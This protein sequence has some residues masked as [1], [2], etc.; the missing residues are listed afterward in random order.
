MI[1]IILGVIIMGS[2][3]GAYENF[4]NKCQGESRRS[5]VRYKNDAPRVIKLPENIEREKK[6][7]HIH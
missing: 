4:R 3:F 6:R 2:L 7:R 5:A 1:T